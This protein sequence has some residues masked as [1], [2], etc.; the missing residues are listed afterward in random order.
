MRAELW[1][2]KVCDGVMG[3]VH[4]QYFQVIEL[5][6]PGMNIALNTING[7][8]CFR[9]ENYSERYGQED[10]VKVHDMEISDETV[11]HF[12]EY[13]NACSLIEDIAVWFDNMPEVKEI[14]KIKREKQL[15]E[16]QQQL[17]DYQKLANGE[18]VEGD[19]PSDD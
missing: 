6:V 1:I 12:E 3:H 15:A 5:Y 2:V 13:I 7:I 14:T 18:D 16:M 10:S 11:K 9:P 4:G 8:N 17:V 19:S